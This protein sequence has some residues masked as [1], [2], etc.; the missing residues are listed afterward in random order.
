MFGKERGY[1][2]AESTDNRVLFCRYECLRFARCFKQGL[3]VERLH[4][5]H[6]KYAY[7]KTL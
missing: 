4:C 7:R 2:L 3:V 5:R 6:V 1:G